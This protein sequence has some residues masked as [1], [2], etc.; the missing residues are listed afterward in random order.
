MELGCYLD[1]VGLEYPIRGTAYLDSYMDTSQPLW[2]EL[3]YYLQ[4]MGLEHSVRPEAYL[5]SYMV[6]PLRMGLLE[7]KLEMGD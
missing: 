1:Q 5:D 7:V 6:T 4:Q 3:G 2:M